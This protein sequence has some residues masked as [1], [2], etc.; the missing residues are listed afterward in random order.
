MQELLNN[1][2]M[3][4][5]LKMLFAAVAIYLIKQQQRLYSQIAK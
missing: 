1:F 3:S 5:I 4:I 2:Y